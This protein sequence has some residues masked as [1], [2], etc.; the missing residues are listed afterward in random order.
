M[1]NTA[2]HDVRQVRK[3]WTIPMS[4]KHVMVLF[5][6]NLRVFIKEYP[7]M[8]F[9]LR[10]GGNRTHAGANPD[11]IRSVTLTTRP[12]EYI[13]LVPNVPIRYTRLTEWLRSQTV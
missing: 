10:Y 2:L 12:T 7:L 13:R 6:L 5:F 1:A 8:K 9:A 3:S 11:L 4:G